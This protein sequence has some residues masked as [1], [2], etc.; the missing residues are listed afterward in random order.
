MQDRF[1]GRNTPVL[2]A[3][4]TLLHWLADA[5]L[6]PHALTRTPESPDNASP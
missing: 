5:A 4:I 2:I 1:R 3:P 6:S